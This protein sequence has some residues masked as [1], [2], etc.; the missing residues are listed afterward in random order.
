MYFPDKKLDFNDNFLADGEILREGTGCAARGDANRKKV[1]IQE[2]GKVVVKTSAVS[3]KIAPLFGRGTA[4]GNKD[5]FGRAG[6]VKRAGD[7][8]DGGTEI[9]VDGGAVN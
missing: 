1:S 9:F 3:D 4:A 7:F 6:V 8:A 5:L 2:R